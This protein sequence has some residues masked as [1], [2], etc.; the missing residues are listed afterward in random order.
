MRHAAEMQ[1]PGLESHLRAPHSL[2]VKVKK[3]QET[4]YYYT[5]N[6]QNHLFVVLLSSEILCRAYFMT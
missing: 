4:L 6:S 3:Q 2:S 5:Q 1:P